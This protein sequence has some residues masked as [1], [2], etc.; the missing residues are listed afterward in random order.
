[1][2]L[3]TTRELA[4]AIGVSESSLKRWVDAG[5][6]AATRTEGGHRRIE[7]GEAMRFIRASG[8][9]VVRPDLLDL[10]EVTAARSKRFVDVL[11]AGDSAGARGWLL[12]R[13]LEGRTVAQLADGP[14]R[15]AMHELGELWRH[16]DSGI[17]VEHRATDACLHAVAH[18]RGMLSE[19]P[20]TAPVAVGAAPTED[21]YL[22]P[23]Q[24]VAMSLVEVGVQAVNLGPD[25]P[26]T[27]L[28][29]AV[30]EYAPQLVWL[31]V[32]APLASARARAYARC[33][34]ALPDSVQIVV[35]GQQA[36]SLGALPPRVKRVATLGQLAA[37]G[38]GL[39]TPVVAN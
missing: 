14:I 12:A 30:A 35:G 27:A 33:L 38:A 2:R 37:V 22:L 7:L 16:D 9:S 1:M 24:L 8:S 19:P 4:D 18:L 34:E 39:V 31:S 17:Y 28:A 25:T 5:K 20:S 13:Y 36:T 3:L 32:T 23:S 15:E 10:P 29:A 6:I 26:Y 21:L 11:R